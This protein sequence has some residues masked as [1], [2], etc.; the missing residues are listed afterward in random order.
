MDE[1]QLVELALLVGLYNLV[2][3]VANGLQ[4]DLDDEAARLLAS[5]R[6]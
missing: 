3:R 6:A 5:L 2:G 4:V 1:R